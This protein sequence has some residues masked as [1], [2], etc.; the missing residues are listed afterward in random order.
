MTEEKTISTTTG[1]DAA[2]AIF[3]LINQSE[4]FGNSKI[5]I[6]ICGEVPWFCGKNIA[7]VL[8]YKNT[9]QALLDHVKSKNKSSLEGLYS[10]LRG[11]DSR[12]LTD[13]SSPGTKEL[14]WNQKNTI[15]I[16]EAGLYQ[17]IMKSK[18]EIA[19]QFQDWVTDDLLPKIRKIGQEKF[20]KQLEES[21]Q[22]IAQLEGK[23]L[24]LEAFVRNIQKLEKNQLFYIA[25]TPNYAKQNRFEYGGI[26]QAKDVKSRLS[27]YN[28][29]RAQGDLYY[30]TKLF[31]CNNYKVIEERLGSVLQQFKDKPDA[32]KE[33][34]ILRYNLLLEIVDFICENCD[35]E[36]EYINARCQQ[37]LTET[38]EEE[39]IIPE[40]IDLTDY[41]EITVRKNND[42]VRQK[43]IDIT[44]WSDAQ[45][46]ALFEEKINL[47]FK[48]I[49]YNFS[50]Q[51][52]TVPLE[53]S[54]SMLTPY[55]KP[56]HGLA[57][58]AWREKFRDWYVK[59]KPKQLKIRGIKMEGFVSKPLTVG[60]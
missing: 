43:R 25:T 33:M 60:A 20:I 12:P 44:G 37:F 38:I 10:K 42:T 30:Y 45:I 17:L 27:S 6:I 5:N 11:Q 22:Q 28:T 48:Q 1:S 40:A 15:Y 39:S 54:W 18:L 51:K 14:K 49:Q 56:Y 53:V 58:M 9:K 19:E 32:R 3:N 34:V 41:V 26:S 21:K 4:Q 7:T 16:N 8:G 2:D 13:T 31:K 47:Y 57:M 55:L 36:I 23:Q 59:E 52:D 50:T 46:D 24:K 29:G 35:R